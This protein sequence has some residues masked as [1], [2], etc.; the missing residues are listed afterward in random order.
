MTENIERIGIKHSFATKVTLWMLGMTG[1]VFLLSFCGA[2]W[3]AGK[4]M[5]VDGHRKANLELDKAILNITDDLDEV[6]AAGNNFAT[7]LRWNGA[8]TLS[9]DAFRSVLADFLKTNPYVQGAAVC[10]EPEYFT[11]YKE[12]FAPYLM[13]LRKGDTKYV[14]LADVYKYRTT[15]WYKKAKSQSQR[16]SFWTEAFVETNGTIVCSYCVPLTNAKGKLVG[17]LALDMSLQAL[18][19][20]VQEQKPYPHSYIT[21]MDDGFHFLVHPDRKMIMDGNVNHLLDKK[22]FAVNESIMVDMKNQRRG[23]GAFVE[24]GDT[25]FLYYAPIRRCGW[26]VT[27]EC[28]KDEIMAEVSAVRLQMVFIS[29]VGLLLLLVISFFLM[30]KIL[31]P[32]KLYS[33]A[34]HRIAKGNFHTHLQ[35]L[36]PHDELWVLGNALDHM[37][38]SLE[39]YIK[40]LK[41]TTQAKG[42]I[43]SELNIASKIQMAMIPKIFPPYP[44]REDLDVYATLIPAK[45]VGGDLY[46]FFLRDE[47]LFFCIGDVSG[48]GVPASLVM[49]VTRSLLRIVAAQESRPDRIVASLNNSMSDMN[50]TN[51]FVTLFVGVLDLPTGRFRYCNAGHNAPVI[52]E[53]E[54]RE[55]RMLDVKPN[56]PIAIM[57]N[58][59]FE[60]QET[61]LATDSVLFMY[62]DGLTE[63]ENK[64][65]E[66]FGED[67]MMAVLKEKEDKCTKEQID[68]MLEAVHRHV[69]GAEQ[70]DD[71]TMISLGYKRQE[72]DTKFY[73]R[74]TLHNDIR[75]TP[76]IADFIDDIVGETGIDMALACSLNLALEEAVVNVMNYAYPEGQTGNITIESYAFDGSLKFVIT[77]NGIPFDP[78]RVKEPDV[79]TGIEDRKVGGL[80]IFLVNRIMDKV[81]YKRM[82][83]TNILTLSK[84]LAIVDNKE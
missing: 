8:E 43:E 24:D 46:D 42:R 62:T 25:K 71:L 65:K 41:V 82:N 44:E 37:Q 77:D 68:A 59:T 47:K 19:D 50:E 23:K 67:R 31:L 36:R 15:R 45:A 5:L 33:K 28:G 34:A 12:G 9:P 64:E 52:I 2:S 83:N 69:G 13:Q 73:R 80:G 6:E 61:M 1:L 56:L 39:R 79:T 75:E 72:R 26:T 18:T 3:F 32:I 40:E 10:F 11:Q 22:R 14:N 60:L 54:T 51:M 20:E 78:T 57:P 70:S 21:V 29:V 30:R 66:L 7:F 27:L 84:K 76:K 49:A 16:H 58:W 55:V 63:A 48:K 35:L 74:R 17:V 4:M 81:E 38:H 53:G